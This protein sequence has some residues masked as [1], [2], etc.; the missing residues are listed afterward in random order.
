MDQVVFKDDK[1]ALTQVVE[2]F[3]V[4]RTE[5]RAPAEK[6]EHHGNQMQN[7]RVIL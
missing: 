3:K 5:P 7:L 2:G 4:L 6:L 1:D